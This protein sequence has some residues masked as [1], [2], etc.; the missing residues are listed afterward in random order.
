MKSLVDK[1]K[2][3]VLGQ[4]VVDNKEMEILKSR[5]PILK[6]LN[7]SWESG[8]L[9]GIYSS[10][11]GDGM[12]VTSVEDIYALGKE[13]IIVLKPYDVAG[14]ILQRGI[15]SINEIRALCPFKSLYKN[16]F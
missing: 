1:F 7:Y 6:A 11:L 8:S 5:K 3:A 14:C 12:F 13:E 9:I 15:L 10:A 16:P 4:P 2:V